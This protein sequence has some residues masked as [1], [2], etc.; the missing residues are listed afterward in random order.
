MNTETTSY[1][2]CVLQEASRKHGTG[3]DRLNTPTRSRLSESMDQPS[4]SQAR[5]YPFMYPQNA[6]APSNTRRVTSG[7]H[8]S[9]RQSFPYPPNSKPSAEYYIKC[10][11]P[12]L[13]S[14]SVL[15]FNFYFYLKKKNSVPWL[16]ISRLVF[17]FESTG[18]IL[19]SSASPAPVRSAFSQQN[20]DAK[21]ATDNSLQNGEQ[22]GLKNSS[23]SGLAP[24]HP[25][26]QLYRQR[27]RN[28]QWNLVDE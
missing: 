16:W 22:G 9:N 7:S 17:D 14:T 27:Q 21:S 15:I 25:L 11:F 2:S 23:F 26:F 3:N 18:T 4:E 6:S 24:D 12:F 19:A 28:R 20:K 1:L 10:Q 5:N 13:F 8:Q